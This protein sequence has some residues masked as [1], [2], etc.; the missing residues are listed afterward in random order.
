MPLRQRTDCP[1]VSPDQRLFLSP[2]PSLDLPFDGNCVG[3][4]QEVLSSAQTN[5]TGNRFDV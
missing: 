5:V 2:G 1:V 3:N 4:I